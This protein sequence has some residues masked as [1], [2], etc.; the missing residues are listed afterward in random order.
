MAGDKG[1]VIE[2]LNGRGMRHAAE[3]LFC[4]VETMILKG[5]HSTSSR[6]MGILPMS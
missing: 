3:M 2:A 4:P 6:G 1:V 5:V